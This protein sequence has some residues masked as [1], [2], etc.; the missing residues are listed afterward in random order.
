MSL[1][2]CPLC[3]EVASGKVVDSR[4]ANIKYEVVRRR[5]TCDACGGRYT[6]YEVDAT[7]FDAMVKRSREIDK[8]RELLIQ[9]FSAALPGSGVTGDLL[10]LR[11]RPKKGEPDAA[12]S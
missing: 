10:G 8:V 7:V 12:V 11:L 1:M 9:N 6:T 5:R 2:K 4:N 3:G